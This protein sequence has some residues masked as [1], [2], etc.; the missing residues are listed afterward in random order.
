MFF[1]RVFS[2]ILQ[3]MTRKTCGTG[4]RG[5]IPSNEREH[6]PARAVVVVGA[7][8]HSAGDGRLADATS[9]KVLRSQETRLKISASVANKARV[10]G[11]WVVFSRYLHLSFFS[12]GLCRWHWV[13][14]GKRCNKTKFRNGWQ[15]RA[16]QTGCSWLKVYFSL[17]ATRSSHNCIGVFVNLLD[18]SQKKD[19][20]M[21]EMIPTSNSADIVSIWN[22]E[23]FTGLISN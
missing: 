15:L 11:R 10:G 1:D 19:N 16:P 4:A 18:S 8:G 23:S 5:A 2:F 3:W 22:N 14:N 17:S 12:L 6:Q 9:Q 7:D 13:C 20:E 21:N